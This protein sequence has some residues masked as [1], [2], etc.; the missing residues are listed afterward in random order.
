MDFSFKEIALV[1]SKLQ[2]QTFFDIME[3]FT[4]YFKAKEYSV[5]RPAVTVKEKY[6][7]DL[8]LISQFH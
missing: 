2:Y 8:F 1:L 5:Y 7:I 3:E 4:R 6:A